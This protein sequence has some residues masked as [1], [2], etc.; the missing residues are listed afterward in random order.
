MKELD[1][2][3]ERFL[4]AAYDDLSAD[5]RRAFE[6]LLLNEDPDLYDLLARKIEPVDA[7]QADIIARI[8]ACAR[9]H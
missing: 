4:A 8:G 3:L 1:V 9:A 7:M 6:A 2:L 5:E